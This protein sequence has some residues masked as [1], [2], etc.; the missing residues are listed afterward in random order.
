[1]GKATWEP[2]KHV[3]ESVNVKLNIPGARRCAEKQV[4]ARAGR[5]SERREVSGRGAGGVQ[6]C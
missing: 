2:G 5:S 6:R 3:P 1:M 4:E